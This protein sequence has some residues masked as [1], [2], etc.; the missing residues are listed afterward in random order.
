MAVLPNGWLSTCRRSLRYEKQSR[1]LFEVG[2]V[3]AASI[4]LL[5]GERVAGTPAVDPAFDGVCL[6]R[7][8]K[9]ADVCKFS[10]PWWHHDLIAR[11]DT[12]PLRIKRDAVVVSSRARAATATSR[13]MRA[14]HGK[15]VQGAVN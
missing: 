11:P 12:E 7:D 13:V 5:K 1:H 3:R 10:L 14:G 2:L 15:D 8:S 6:G 9:F 4:P